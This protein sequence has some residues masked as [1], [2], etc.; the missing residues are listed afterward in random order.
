MF[1]LDLL[2]IIAI[3]YFCK[4][5]FSRY[6]PAEERLD[7]MLVNGEINEEDYIIKKRLL[8]KMR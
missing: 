3:V 6:S 2:L 8:N 7:I 4:V 5:S 1:L